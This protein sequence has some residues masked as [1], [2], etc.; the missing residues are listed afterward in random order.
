MTTPF[1]LQVAAIYESNMQLANY[2]Q[3]PKRIKKKFNG[4]KQS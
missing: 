3:S 1:P 2:P 4:K